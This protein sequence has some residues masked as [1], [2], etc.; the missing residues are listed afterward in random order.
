MQLFNCLK[1]TPQFGAVVEM[2]L[3]GIASPREKLHPVKGVN[4]FPS[5]W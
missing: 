2:F 1:E 5:R 4:T 3:V